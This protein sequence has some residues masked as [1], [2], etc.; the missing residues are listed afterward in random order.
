M[1]NERLLNV[2]DI[3]VRLDC[4]E[5]TVYNHLRAGRLKATRPGRRW[6]ISEANYREFLAECEVK[7]HQPER[8]P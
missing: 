8:T 7:K 2:L 1:P 6:L 5:R 3:A 4:C